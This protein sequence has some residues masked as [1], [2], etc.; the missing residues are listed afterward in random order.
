MDEAVRGEF[1]R[2]LSI[3]SPDT[4]SPREES[5]RQGVLQAMGEALKEGDPENMFIYMY[6]CIYTLTDIYIHMFAYQYKYT[7]I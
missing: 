5:P 6:I 1:L 2:L 4:A 7:H 3:S